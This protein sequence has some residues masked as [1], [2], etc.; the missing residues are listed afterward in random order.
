MI[1]NMQLSMFYYRYIIDECNTNFSSR[2]SLL[3]KNPSQKCLHYLNIDK[4]N[5]FWINLMVNICAT[6]MKKN[7]NIKKSN[8]I[9]NCVYSSLHWRL[10]FAIEVI[11]GISIHLCQMFLFISVLIGKW[12]K[13]ITSYASIAVLSIWLICFVSSILISFAVF[14]QLV[15]W[16]IISCNIDQLLIEDMSW[17]LYMPDDHQT[18]KNFIYSTFYGKNNVNMNKIRRF[19]EIQIF[20]QRPVHLKLLIDD[21]LSMCSR[22][23]AI[24]VN[25][26]MP[27]DIVKI[28]IDY[29]YEKLSTRSVGVFVLK[30]E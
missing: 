4:L 24:L 19:V 25:L 9:S 30:L 12:N 8:L 27:Y 5:Q 22:R 16:E 3:H 1:L 14:R 7:H 29:G 20:F 28:I 15:N 18:G 2:I 11:F 26:E 17:I 13:T 6:S 10:W 23:N 21:Y